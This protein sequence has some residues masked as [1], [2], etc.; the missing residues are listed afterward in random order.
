M[1][2]ILPLAALMATLSGCATLVQ[3]LGA[4]GKAPGELAC[5]GRAV[6]AGSGNISATL[7]ISAANDFRL[8]FD[9]GQDGAFIRQGM[10]PLQTAPVQ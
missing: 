7:G 2:L 5:K 4:A 10:P 1:K 9:C 6:I 8:S 3:D